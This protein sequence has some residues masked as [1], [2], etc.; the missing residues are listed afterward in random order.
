MRFSL[1]GRQQR[2]RDVRPACF[3]KVYAFAD[4]FRKR[5]GIVRA[6]AHGEQPRL[7]ARRN[8]PLGQILRLGPQTE[9]AGCLRGIDQ[10]V[11]SLGRLGSSP[12]DM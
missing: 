5:I 11:N 2:R 7:S 4:E 1:A 6:P 12:I 10:R 3:D 8:Q 9:Q